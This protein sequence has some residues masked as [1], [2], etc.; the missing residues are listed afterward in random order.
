[1]F[2]HI[3]KQRSFGTFELSGVILCICLKFFCA[4]QLSC[5]F[6][7]SAGASAA[8]LLQGTRIESTPQNL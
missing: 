3:D 5:F 2:L 4:K 8:K 6:I 1:M 7:G